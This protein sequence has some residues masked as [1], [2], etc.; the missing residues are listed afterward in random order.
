M[1]PDA[2][3][4]VA[5]SDLARS[6]FA[7]W[8]ATRQ[9]ILQHLEREGRRHADLVNRFR[10][11][12]QLHERQTVLVADPK[13]TKARTG[14]TPWKRPLG[15]AGKVVAVKGSKVDTRCHNGIVLRDILHDWVVVIPG[16]VVDH[17]VQPRGVHAGTSTGVAAVGCA[18]TGVAA[19]GRSAGAAGG[20]C[21]AGCVIWRT[22]GL[23]VF[24][25]APFV[26]HLCVP[27]F[28]AREQVFS[29]ISPKCT[30]GLGSGTALC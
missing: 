10:V 23:V 16:D 12:K 3:E 19:V 7:E 15:S 9:L 26:W 11:P 8:R 17:E 30:K 20:S 24:F 29:D 4:V 27:M 13:L 14:R 1:P 5:V 25:Y 21:Q 18:S 22:P 2:G 6:Q 28:G